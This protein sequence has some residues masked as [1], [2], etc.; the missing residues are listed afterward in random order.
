MPIIVVL[1][2]IGIIAALVYGGM[3]LFTL[4]SASAGVIAAMLS[5]LIAAAILVAPF[6]VWRRRYLAIHGKKQQGQ[7]ILEL[8]LP[9]G[10]IRLDALQKRGQIQTGQGAR[11]FIF[12]DIEAVELQ[13]R[14]LRLTLRNPAQSWDI[15]PAHA[16]EAKRWHK[17]LSLAAR[18]DL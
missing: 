9:D 13:S 1:L 15:Q 10:A 14:G 17:I 6:I 18:Q 3:Q 11:G 5:L 8:A 4:V 12:A 2:F 7:R 16:A